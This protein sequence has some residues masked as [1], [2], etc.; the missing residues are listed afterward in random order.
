MFFIMFI[1]GWLG[2]FYEFYKV[3]LKFIVVLIDDYV[4]LVICLLILG[5]GLLEV[6]YKLGFE[7]FVVGCIFCKLMECFGYEFYYI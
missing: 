5:Y 1:Y 7:L 2:L 6:F 4:F 3:I